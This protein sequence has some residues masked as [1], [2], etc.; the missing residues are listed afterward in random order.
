MA[1][2]RDKGFKLLPLI[3]K[4]SRYSPAAMMAFYSSIL[5]RIVR[6]GGDVF[7]ER[8]KLSKA[9]KLT[10]AAGVYLRHRFFSFTAL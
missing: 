7:T 5:R 2:Y 9:E 10:L 1:S 3:P 8:V 4:Q 6:T